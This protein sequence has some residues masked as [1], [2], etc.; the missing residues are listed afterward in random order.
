[1]ASPYRVIPL[2]K[3]YV[4]IVS[5]EDYRRVNKYEWH[6]HVSKGT[7]KKPGQPYARATI[8]GKKVYLHRFVMNTPEW[9][10][11]DHLN[12][13]TLDCRRE[14]LENVAHVENQRRRRNVLKPTNIVL[15]CQPAYIS[16][17]A[18]VGSDHNP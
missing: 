5:A 14:N 1:M 8:N 15:P 2:T 9:M 10:Q 17:V 6:V 3:G 18:S 7:K 13:Q 16:V 11:A 4:A 12:H